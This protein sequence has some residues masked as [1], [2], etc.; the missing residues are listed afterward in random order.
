MTFYLFLELICHV[1]S[2]YYATVTNIIGLTSDG[3]SSKTLL[4]ATNAKL[5]YDRSTGRIV[6]FHDTDVTLSSV[7]LDGTGKTVISS[8][9]RLSR[10]AIDY[11]SRTLYYIDPTGN[12]N[13]KSLNLTNSS[14]TSVVLE[15]SGSLGGNVR[16]VDVDPEMK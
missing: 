8:G 5:E 10:F 14:D 1:D 13:I 11:S 7:K 6:Y 15:S 4:S 3:V 9:E 16:D 12:N 2:I